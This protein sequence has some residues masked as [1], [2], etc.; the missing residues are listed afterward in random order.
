M[1]VIRQITYH[2]TVLTT[3]FFHQY[4][5]VRVCGDAASRG[6]AFGATEGR[7]GGDGGVY[8]VCSFVVCTYGG[9]DV[10]GSVEEG[11]DGGEEWA[12]GGGGA[13]L[14]TLRHD[15]SMRETRGMKR[16]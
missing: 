7:A 16:T 9:A 14:S 8:G 6:G 10:E 12:Y 5:H 3:Y 4:R 1:Y 2:G 13:C 15:F 11:K